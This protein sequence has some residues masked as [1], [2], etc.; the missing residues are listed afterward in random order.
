MQEFPLPTLLRENGFRFFFYSN[1][2]DEPA[3]VHTIGRGGEAK[4][5]LEP[6]KIAYLY[7]LSDR[8]RR[9]ILQII[10]ENVR[11]FRMKWRAWHGSKNK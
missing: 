9:E 7:R 2:R 8:D 4:V 10:F 3:H 1:E 5:W 6:V 11:D